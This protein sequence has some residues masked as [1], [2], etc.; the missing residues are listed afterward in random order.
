M[1]SRRA[2]YNGDNTV[3]YLGIYVL[4][5]GKMDLNSEKTYKEKK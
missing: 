1:M 5:A 4:N 2:K 3:K